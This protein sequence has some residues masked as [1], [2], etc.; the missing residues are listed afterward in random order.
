MRRTSWPS[1]LVLSWDAALL[2]LT[3]Q[4]ARCEGLVAS[5]GAVL[6]LLWV[7]VHF[8]LLLHE[9]AH[10]AVFRRPLHNEILG[11]LLGFVILCPFLTR[12]RSHALHHAWTGHPG[13]D[14]T[15]ARAIRRL[16]SMSRR[17][18][19][20]L[21]VLWRAYVPVLCLN[22]RFGLLLAPFVRDRAVRTAVSERRAVYV[23]LTGYLVTFACASEGGVPWRA[24]AIYTSAL[25]LS[26]VVEEMINLPHHLHAPFTEQR[27]ALSQQGAVTHSC[28]HLP[29]WSRYV[30]LNFGL[31]EAH[32]R[33]PALPWC[34][35]PAAH[36]ELLLAGQPSMV[37]NELAWTYHQRR[38][39]FVEALGQYIDAPRR[40]AQ[41][42]PS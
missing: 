7:L 39:P 14:P 8:Y 33:W 1:L 31:H 25:L 24:A 36:R 35:L 22:E 6:T 41:S 34:D 23:G 21:D 37:S 12:R 30:L 32:H 10:G 15:N 38:R 17:K 19:L 20:L 2:V 27:L 42:S 13:R 18:L 5:M 28:A 9:C 40:A 16:S 11:H 29:F 4:L 3:S 26:L